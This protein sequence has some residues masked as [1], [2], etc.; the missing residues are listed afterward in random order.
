MAR[1]RN[2]RRLPERESGVPQQDRLA[3]MLGGRGRVLRFI[4]LFSVLLAGYFV[5]SA[6]I[7][8]QSADGVA[9]RPVLARVLAVKDAVQE[10]VIQ[11]YQRSLAAGT[12]AVVRACGFD[13][14]VEG[15]DVRR[16]DGGFSVTITNGCDS[17]ELTLLVVV[18]MLCFPVAWRW[19]LAGAV[20]AIG[21]I[22]LLNFVRIVSLWIIGVCWNG[23]FDFAHFSVWPFVLVCGAIAVF[24]SWLRFAVPQPR[25]S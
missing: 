13:A 23:A 25:A 2:H 7:R 17:V 16:A 15:R 18:A 6:S 9:A 10:S 20:S 3:V 19:R 11:P 14:V 8:F 4:G 22:A 21:L 24:A 1:R 5:L 12:G